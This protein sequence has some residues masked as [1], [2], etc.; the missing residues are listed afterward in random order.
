MSELELTDFTPVTEWVLDQGLGSTD[1]ETL[2]TG[3]C[4]RFNRLGMPIMRGHVSISLLHPRFEARSFS[5][6][7]GEG[8]IATGHEVGSSEGRDWQ[9]SPLAA[10]IA[11][12]SD[13]L[14]FRI[15][16]G[17][18]LDRF[19]VFTGFAER[20][21]TDYVSFIVGFGDEETAIER[22]DGMVCSWITDR[23]GGF[24]PHEVAALR[25]LC[26]RFGLAV[27]TVVREELA[28][29]VVNAYLGPRAGAKVL[30]GSLHLGDGEMIEAVIW[31]SDLRDSS[32]HLGEA[33][34]DG[35]LDL[36]NRYFQC[37]AGP[38]MAAGGDVLRFV[39][40]AM[41]AMF[42]L[43]RFGSREAAAAAAMSAW[44]EARRLQA[45]EN[46]GGEADIGFSVGLH[47]GEL[48]Y[49]NV[50]VEERLEFTVVGAAA[51]LAARLERQASERGVP[52]VLSAEVA[53]YCGQPV[54][55]LGPA[56]L[57]GFADP[58]ELFMPED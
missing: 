44:R 42:P 18:G 1:V 15:E 50:G 37:T 55:S 28:Q 34:I 48:L 19:P 29:S 7:R 52:M 16:S 27:K 26:R 20:G 11:S 39:G 40:D 57:R 36:M 21:A 12:R 43:D 17:E 45:A 30:D 3:V 4:E 9:E 35:Y 24:S 8:V 49:G 10:L 14:R 32:R 38:V 23:A 13:S 33:G 58:V 25:R 2:L 47:A 56:E 53:R 41:L 31:F 5:W 51:N 46:A 22:S 6:W 54:R